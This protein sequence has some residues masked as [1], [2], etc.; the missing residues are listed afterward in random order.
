MKAIKELEETVSTKSDYDY[1]K[2]LK[3]LFYD[4]K[5]CLNNRTDDDI[6][7]ISNFIDN[8]IDDYFQNELDIAIEKA[9]QAVRDGEYEHNVFFEPP[10]KL[11]DYLG[12]PIEYEIALEFCADTRENTTENEALQRVLNY[13]YDGDISDLEDVK[14]YEIM[15][16]MALKHIQS[17]LENSDVEYQMSE[18]DD[19]IREFGLENDFLYMAKQR[20]IKD[21]ID[22]C[23][24]VN[25]CLSMKH[26][27]ELHSKLQVQ[28]TEIEK[29]L[30]K[31][32]ASKGG[33]ARHKQSNEMK[34]KA[35]DEYKREAECYK[36]QG[37][38]LS[39]NDFARKFAL[40]YNLNETTVRKNWLQGLK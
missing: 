24:S 29:N 30:L 15:A 3:G 26:S 4:I 13:Y 16:V 17:A 5:K 14:D 20:A 21:S 6:N 11:D 12:C 9:R 40:N 39:K 38:V 2:Q 8:S 23:L 36:K 37:K 32:R 28:K 19:R 27:E 33:K 1:L 34:K 35:Q 22:A 7:T 25:E 10:M 31:E 18:L